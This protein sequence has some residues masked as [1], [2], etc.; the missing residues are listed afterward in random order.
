[1][2]NAYFVLIEV[3]Q[4][5]WLRHFVFN[6]HLRISMVTQ[7]SPK[8]PCQI[9]VIFDCDGTLLDSMGMWHDLD[10]RIA[11]KA[12]VVF[13]KADRDYLTAGTLL[14][15]G[16]YMH[17]KFGIGESGPAVAN[18]IRE[19]VHSY[20]MN[21][22]QAKPGAL[23][24][25]KGLH[26]L[27]IPMA[28]AS[29]TPTYLLEAGLESCGFL[30]YLRAVVSVEDVGHSKREPH[31]YDKA[32]ESL[33][34]TRENTWGFEDA[35]YAVHTLNGAGYKTCAIFDSQVAGTPQDLKAAA[36]HYI[37]SFEQLTPQ[38]FLQLATSLA[39]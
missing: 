31:V 20:Y 26:E 7:N 15:C 25:V 18:M 27:G 8:T 4:L 12:G 34:T 5:F 35:I 38:T 32:R 28:V 9:G 10:D 6:L 2:P 13:E 1:L 21:E 30:P 16:T 17:E 11:E 37:D 23:E 29:S 19:D 3:P 14:E 39:E 22:A 33:G 36:A 24:F